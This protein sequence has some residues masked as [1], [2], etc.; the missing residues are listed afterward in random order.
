MGVK[1]A[2]LPLCPEG[3]KDCNQIIS[4]NKLFDSEYEVSANYVPILPLRAMV[5]ANVYKE[6]KSLTM[7]RRYYIKNTAGNYTEYQKTFLHITIKGSGIIGREI[8]AEGTSNDYPLKYKNVM[9][10]G[11]PKRAHMKINATLDGITILQ[12]AVQ[13]DGDKM[14]NKV[15]GTYL[16]KIVDYQTNWRETKGQLAGIPY[17]LHTEGLIKEKDAFKAITKGT[18]GSSSIHGEVNMI[19]PNLFE[20]VEYYGPIMV[21]TEIIVLEKTKSH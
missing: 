8:N 18:I 17:Q 16:G 5:Q 4:S 3:S 20:S 1:A 10:F 15:S 6:K 2:S 7:D 19:K 12:L 21:K 9:K 13:S 11:L 14:T